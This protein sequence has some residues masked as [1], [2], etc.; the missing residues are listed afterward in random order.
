[1]CTAGPHRDDQQHQGYHAVQGRIGRSTRL[2]TWIGGTER[3]MVVDDY[4]LEPATGHRRRGHQ[5][6]TE[7]HTYAE[8]IQLMIFAQIFTWGEKGG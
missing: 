4:S 7:L 6:C 1:M 5:S 2:A 3:A 8:A